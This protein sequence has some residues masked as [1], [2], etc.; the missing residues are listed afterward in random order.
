MRIFA[1]ELNNDIKGLDARKKYIESLIFQLSKPDIVLFPE[2]ALPS[3]M[4]NYKIWEYADN[5]SINTSK[6]AKDMAKKY[7]CYIGIGYIDYENGDYYN[8][9]LI[10]DSKQV[11]GIVTKSEAEAAVFKRG[12]FNNIIKTPF[13]NVAVAIC[14]D[15]KRKYFYNNIENEKISLIIFPHGSPSSS[16]NIENEVKINDYICNLYVNAF[17]V[18]VVYI[19]SYG[20]LEHMPG[21]TGKLMSFLNFTMNGKSKIYGSGCENIKLT[22]KNIIGC[23]TILYENYKTNEI[24]FYG[25]DLIK[26]NSFFRKTILKMDIF[27]GLKKYKKMLKETKYGL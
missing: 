2:L 3:Y 19:N 1:L 7:N 24:L 10:A 27:L 18:P 21:I 12:Y 22:Q 17:C 23:E 11:Y 16:K 5:N 15:S 20:K 25:L 4:P 8:R 6:W 9:Y 14:Y 13:G 26:G